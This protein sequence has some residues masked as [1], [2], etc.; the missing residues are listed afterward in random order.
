MK[1]HEG[2]VKQTEAEECRRFYCDY[3]NTAHGHSG[4]TEKLAAEHYS[5]FQVWC[6]TIIDLFGPLGRVEHTISF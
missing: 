2:S 1:H 4:S 3:Y 6:L 5:F